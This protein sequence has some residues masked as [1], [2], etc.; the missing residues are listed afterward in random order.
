MIKGDSIFLTELFTKGSNNK[1]SM[2]NTA[3]K[4][5]TYSA[6]FIQS[7][8]DSNRLSRKY[9]IKEN[10]AATAAHNTKYPSG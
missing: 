9:K 6:R 10:S 5:S 1:T 2:I 8:T 3:A 7:D 4:R